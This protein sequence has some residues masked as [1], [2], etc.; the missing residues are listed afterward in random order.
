M[1][2]QLGHCESN[3]LDNSR[4]ARGKAP[5][6]ATDAR[7]SDRRRPA[8]KC[9]W[10]GWFE[11]GRYSPRSTSPNP[12]PIAAEVCSGETPSKGHC[13][14]DPVGPCIRSGCGSRSTWRSA[15]S[16][17]T[18][19]FSRWS[20][21]G[22]W[23]DTAWVCPRHGRPASSKRQRA[24][25]DDGVSPSA[26]SWR[27]GDHPGDRRGR[28]G[29]RR[30]GCGDRRRGCGAWPGS[31]GPARPRRHTD[32]EPRRPLAPERRRRCAR[33]TRSPARTRDTRVDC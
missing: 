19:D 2:A 24:R 11:T 20:R 7:R 9:T 29:D 12:A 3:A 23:V 16:P 21:S 28:C 1:G 4:P 32:R 13:C 30:R 33:P 25:S 27:S 26:T 17:T 5:P 8:R 6:P 31:S 18:R 14:C 15:V 22:G 10:G